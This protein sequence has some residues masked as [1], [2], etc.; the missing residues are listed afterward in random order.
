MENNQL[1]FKKCCVI[2]SLIVIFLQNLY[3]QKTDLVDYLF[4]KRSYFE[5]VLKPVKIPFGSKTMVVFGPEKR[6]FKSYLKADK[7]QWVADQDT[8]LKAFLRICYS[9]NYNDTFLNMS[10][11][12]VLIHAIVKALDCG[13][14]VFEQRAYY[15][16]ESIVPYTSLDFYG[17]EIINRLSDSNLKIENKNKL[18]AQCNPSDEVKKSLLNDSL[19]SLP[20]RARLGDKKAEDSLII[21]FKEANGF[22]AADKAVQELFLCGSKNCMSTIIKEFNKPIYQFGKYGCIVGG[23]RVSIINGF[24]RYFPNDTLINFEYQWVSKKSS[25]RRSDEPYYTA[26]SSVAKFLNEFVTWGKEK[27]GTVP[28][29]KIGEPI[30][31]KGP[32]EKVVLKIQEEKCQ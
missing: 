32:C 4:E 3:G 17:M 5:N 22:E 26:D 23:L 29:G 9:N 13:N 6:L 15:L 21:L 27:Y 31:F 18:I 12:T 16:L 14:K 10:R 2:F 8:I 24:Q 20:L 11:D 25:K 28:Y 19:L 7:K 30:L 1:M